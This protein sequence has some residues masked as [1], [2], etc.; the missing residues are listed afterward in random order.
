MYVLTPGPPPASPARATAGEAAPECEEE[1]MKPHPFQRHDLRRVRHRL[2]FWVGVILFL[3]AAMIYVG[4]DDLA[5]GP[6]ST[7]AESP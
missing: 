3:L 1:R 4:T 7:Q 5:V 6:G 2:I